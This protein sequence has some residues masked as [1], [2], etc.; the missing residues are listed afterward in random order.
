[1]DLGNVNN[2]QNLE[3]YNTK[4]NQINKNQELE[5]HKE[6]QVSPLLQSA[7]AEQET[8]VSTNIVVDVKTSYEPKAAEDS[9]PRTGLNS[10]EAEEAAEEASQAIPRTGLQV[11][12]QVEAEEAQRLLAG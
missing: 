1:M 10:K 5:D 7:A 9:D 12:G 3:L 6:D 2:S 11:Q 8:A 4:D